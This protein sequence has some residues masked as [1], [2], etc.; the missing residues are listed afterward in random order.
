MIIYYYLKIQLNYKLPNSKQIY[1]YIQYICTQSH[2]LSKDYQ[3]ARLIDTHTLIDS[4]TLDYFSS[5]Q[6]YR[7]L[8]LLSNR[9]KDTVIN[10][11]IIISTFY[12]DINTV[13]LLTRRSQVLSL[14]LPCKILYWVFSWALLC[15]TQVNKSVSY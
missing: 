3:L 14:L 15:T 10:N 12:R 13:V 5:F 2:I 4:P 1:I 11:T 8:V 6:C 7:A 9:T